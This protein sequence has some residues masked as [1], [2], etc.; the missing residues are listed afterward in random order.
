MEPLRKDTLKEDKPL[1]RDNNTLLIDNL[2]QENKIKF[3]LKS[4]VNILSIGKG[5]PC[6][7]TK[8]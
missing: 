8:G 3:I 7:E 5:R 1:M 4:M 6:N 2:S